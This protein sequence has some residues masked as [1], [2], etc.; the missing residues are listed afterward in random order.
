MP[1]SS[2]SA[3]LSVV[4]DREDRGDARMD[5]GGDGLARLGSEIDDAL[6]AMS[7]DETAGV[8]VGVEAEPPRP[9]GSNSV[10]PMRV[11]GR[12]RGTELVLGTTGL[13]FPNTDSSRINA[14]Q[15]A[16]VRGRSPILYLLSI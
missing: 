8:A 12:A 16:N 15:A 14:T 3:G 10:G 2:E 5:S 7:D 4:R 1:L 6:L 11:R 9:R 13:V